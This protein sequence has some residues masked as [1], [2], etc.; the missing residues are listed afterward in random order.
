MTI[1][2][3]INLF[4]LYQHLFVRRSTSTLNLTQKFLLILNLSESSRNPYCLLFVIYYPEF[5]RTLEVP[6]R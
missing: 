1:I 2:H 3:E 6:I 4:S 5:Y